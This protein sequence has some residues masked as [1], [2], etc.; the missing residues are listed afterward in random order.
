MQQWNPSGDS[1]NVIMLSAKDRRINDGRNLAKVSRSTDASSVRQNGS[2]IGKG[3][4]GRGVRATTV[5]DA[6]I[7]SRKHDVRL[8][9]LCPGLDPGDADQ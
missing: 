7:L 3:P 2:N 9:T 1:W 8:Q 5:I 6:P 4:H